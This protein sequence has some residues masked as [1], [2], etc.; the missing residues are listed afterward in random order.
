MSF[1]RLGNGILCIEQ[2]K[3]QRS[4]SE[5]SKDEIVRK[6]GLRMRATGICRYSLQPVMLGLR[7]SIGS[8]VLPLRHCPSPH[9]R[10]LSCLK[11]S[12]TYLRSALPTSLRL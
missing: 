11:A 8:S 4:N 5:S 6:N 1:M 7:A 3:K 2:V 10:I 9:S 12:R